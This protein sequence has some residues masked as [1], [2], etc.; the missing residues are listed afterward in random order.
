MVPTVRR[1]EGHIGGVPCLPFN[2][3]VRHVTCLLRYGMPYAQQSFVPAA[4]GAMPR[5]WLWREPRRT[6]RHDWRG[7]GEATV[8]TSDQHPFRQRPLDPPRPAER[9]FIARALLAPPPPP[10][11]VPETTWGSS[12]NQTPPPPLVHERRPRGSRRC[13]ELELSV[14]MVHESSRNSITER[15]VVHE[16]RPLRGL[17]NRTV[18]RVLRCA[19]VEEPTE[20]NRW[21]S[22]N[23]QRSQ[24]Q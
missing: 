10:P 23:R 15:A 9:R 8:D 6:G 7:G 5:M 13:T 11:P 3:R 20:L 1:Y 2:W 14:V 16:T 22:Y 21:L 4:D 17:A 24:S 12:V 19:A 18:G